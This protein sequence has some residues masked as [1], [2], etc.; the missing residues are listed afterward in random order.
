MM[1]T[2][3]VCR[4]DESAFIYTFQIWLSVK[5]ALETI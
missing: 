5:N 1:V 2:R 4:G 3:P